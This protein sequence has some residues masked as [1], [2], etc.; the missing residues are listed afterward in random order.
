MIDVNTGINLLQSHSNSKFKNGLEKL[1]KRIAKL[2]SQEGIKV[3]STDK[4]KSSSGSGELSADRHGYQR[5]NFVEP[6]PLSVNIYKKKVDPLAYKRDDQS[7]LRILKARRSPTPSENKRN[8]TVTGPA[9]IRIVEKSS[10]L[11]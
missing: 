10:L 1:K 6:Q 3:P 11:N 7:S 9:R 8:N 2:P 4:A 5:I